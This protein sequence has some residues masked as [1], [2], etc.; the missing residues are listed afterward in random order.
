MRSTGVVPCYPLGGDISPTFVECIDKSGL[1]RRDNHS[2]HLLVCRPIC[3]PIHGCMY[4]S[5]VTHQICHVNGMEKA[6]FARVVGAN[7][8]TKRVPY[9]AKSQYYYLRQFYNC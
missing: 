1:R 7:L 3:R 9:Y 4:T 5:L 8:C 2:P 6:S